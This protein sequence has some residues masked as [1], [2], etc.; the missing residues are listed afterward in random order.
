[1]LFT[2]CILAPIEEEDGIRISVMSRHTL[3]DGVTPDK[4]IAEGSYHSHFEPLAPRPELVGSY[5]RGE[6]D[7]DE[8]KK[9]YLDYLRSPKIKGQVW[10][11]ARSALRRDITLLCIE[12]TPERCHRRILAEEC[13]EHEPGLRVVYN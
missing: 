6:I 9:R 3:E 13:K 10:G 2:K 7:W 1:M 5:L 4:R 8:Y 11:L 12:E